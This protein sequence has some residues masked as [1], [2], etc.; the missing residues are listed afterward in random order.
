MAQS[1][2]GHVSCQPGAAALPAGSTWPL[3]GR[4]PAGRLGGEKARSRRQKRPLR[5]VGPAHVT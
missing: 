2:L 1:G 4:L 5:T 3:W